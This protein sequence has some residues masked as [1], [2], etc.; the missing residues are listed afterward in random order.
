MVFSFSSSAPN[1]GPGNPWPELFPRH[2]AHR[3]IALSKNVN[4]TNGHVVI[5][6]ADVVRNELEVEQFP[7]GVN[8][9]FNFSGPVIARYRVVP[10]TN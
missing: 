5:G 1:Y 7:L 10:E 6:V 9:K 2:C 4:F 8:Y 3:A